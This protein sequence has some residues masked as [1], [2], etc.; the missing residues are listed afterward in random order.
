MSTPGS[1]MRISLRTRFVLAGALLVVT[2]IACGLFTTLMLLRLS[3]VVGAGLRDT[4]ATSAAIAALT[5]GLE[6]EDDVLLLALVPNQRDYRERLL[7]RRAEVAAAFSRLQASLVNTPHREQVEELRTGIEAYHQAGDALLGEL[8]GAASL[9][10][11]HREVNPRLRDAVN[12]C[13]RIGDAQEA[14]VTALAAFTRD[15]AKRGGIVA[16]ILCFFAVILS[17]LIAAHLGRVVVGPVRD[18]TVKVDSIASGDFETRVTPL[19]TDELGRLGEG[20]N[21]MADALA[22]FR[23]SSLGELLRANQTLHATLAALPDAVLVLDADGAVASFNAEAL[24]LFPRLGESTTHVSNLAL[25]PEA[26]EEVSRALRNRT[27]GPESMNFSRAFAIGEPT[28]HRRLLPRVVPFEGSD[29][30]GAVL[31]LYDVTELARLDEMRLELVGVASHELRTPVTTLRM[32]L[33]MLGEEAFD[34][35]QRDLVATAL[36]GVEQLEGTVDGFLD[37]TRIEAGQLRLNLEAVDVSQVVEQVV[38]RFR[39]QCEA[40]G[41]TLGKR[42]EPRIVRR[43]DVARLAVVVNNLLS[44]SGKYTPAGG[45][46]LVQCERETVSGDAVLRVSDSGPG[47]PEEF[48]ERVFD[49]FFRVEHSRDGDGAKGT[50][51]GLYLCRQIVEAHGG[52]IRCGPRPDATGTTFEVTLPRA[53]A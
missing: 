50:G 22:V 20:F 4:E 7:A 14:E 35:R 15:E 48:R 21:R 47:I 27:K 43:V 30:A 2:T 16:S 31:I 38:E 41:V 24:G 25:P 13:A 26:E 51:I 12:A 29:F 6:R 17:G 52:R 28:R 36:V 9:G 42:L 44:N 8:P 53:Q 33:A 3:R 1:R 34:K 49:K 32:T 46:I 18:L 37:L 39:S 45:S 23:R 40:S 5:A 10:R 11:Y 19:S